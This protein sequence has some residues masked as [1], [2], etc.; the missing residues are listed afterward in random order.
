VLGFLNYKRFCSE[1][2][3]KPWEQV[4]SGFGGIWTISRKIIERSK[5]FFY[6]ND[7][8]YEFYKTSDEKRK[9]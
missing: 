6:E 1:N 7:Q 3:E 8:Y 5:K 2:T 9:D 4:L